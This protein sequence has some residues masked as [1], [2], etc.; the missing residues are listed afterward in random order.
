MEF[1]LFLRV[2][3]KRRWLIIGLVILSIVST[4]V[5]IRIWPS[6]VEARTTILFNFRMP[7]DV[8]VYETKAY[9]GP[10]DAVEHFN[11][12]IL[13]SSPSVLKEALAKAGQQI[14]LGPVD[15]K[16]IRQKGKASLSLVKVGG[17]DEKTS[18]VEYVV[19]L[20][21]PARAVVICNAV[22]EVAIKRYKQI[23][24]ESVVRSREY[25]EEQVVISKS[26]LDGAQKRLETFYDENPEFTRYLDRQ[27]YSGENI[28]S[29][30]NV[31]DL[32]VDLASIN[33]QIKQVKSE[34][35]KY[36]K[37]PTDQVPVSIQESPLINDLRS[38]LVQLKLDRDT[39]LTRYK[40]DY[41]QVAKLDSEIVEIRS[42][43]YS[44]YLTLLNESLESLEGKRAELASS[45]GS[46]EQIQNDNTVRYNEFSVKNLQ[47]DGLD[48]DLSV[49][50]SNYR[51]MREKLSEAKI[52]EDEAKNQYTLSIID[53]PETPKD[54]LPKEGIFYKPAFKMI[55]AFLGSL[56]FSLVLVFLMDYF[57][58]RYR[59]TTDL[60]RVI[61]LPILGEVPEY[62]VKG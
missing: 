14:D 33:T 47:Y 29:E 60:A 4:F 10:K 23:L 40:E 17:T 20:Q 27:T 19:S 9:L 8:D 31:I 42:N 61:D 39:L 57:E 1:W 5:S 37:K 36:S 11:F 49:A 12:M 32:E 44:T 26:E 15:L 56:I 51:L 28:R 50:E 46:V 52:R 2:I 18:I 21:N 35:E 13:F 41:P 38:Q 6:P 62:K 30:S 48:R 45:I 34:I 22:A 55:F 59:S 58:V 43:L 24:T 25:L 16:V 54:A 3:T 53:Q 7:R